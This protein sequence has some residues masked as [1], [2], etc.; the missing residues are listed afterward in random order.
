MDI[1]EKIVSLKKKVGKYQRVAVAF[2]GGKDSFFLLKNAVETVGKNNVLAFFVISEFTSDS[3]RKRIK[4]FRKFFDF[5]LKEL[6]VKLS[7][8]RHIMNNHL[9]RCYFCKRKIFQSIIKESSDLN[10][11]IVMDGSTFSDINEYRPGMRALEELNIISP[12]KDLKITSDEVVSVLRNLNIDDYYLTSSTCLATRFPYSHNLNQTELE[13]FARIEKYISELGV[14]PVRI[15]FIKNGIRIEAK[16][17]RF[18]DLIKR[19][20][21]IIEFCRKEGLRYVCLDLAD[22]SAGGWD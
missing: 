5:K 15:R 19:K 9:R 16:E 13:K 6:F 11:D 2:S 4:Y 22:I 10:F 17:D 20:N 3:D 8:E 21:N 12:L 14:Y 1:E 18:T 7:K